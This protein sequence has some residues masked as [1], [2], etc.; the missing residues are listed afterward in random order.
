MRSEKVQEA[1]RAARASE[2]ADHSELR[3]SFRREQPLSPVGSPQPYTPPPPRSSSLFSPPEDD[4]PPLRAEFLVEFVRDFNR[5]SLAESKQTVASER[6]GPPPPRS[7][8]AIWSRTKTLAAS[9]SA[10]NG[11]ASKPHAVKLTSPA[12]IRFMIPDVLTAYISLVFTS[13]EDP[14]IVESVTAFGPREMCFRSTMAKMIQS[15]PRVPFQILISVLV[16]YGGLFVDRCTSCQRVLS[17]EGHFPPVG[18]IWVPKDHQLPP[19]NATSG[20]RVADSIDAAGQVAPP[21]PG[22]GDRTD[23]SS[24]RWEP[25][26]ATCLYN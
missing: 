14:L 9:A 5:G 1:L 7:R 20:K 6:D 17:A 13:L 4:P 3:L 23:H 18:R 12:V 21:A 8:L 15:H 2:E 25:R 24:G 11:I 10:A 26:H 16:S 22:A 19:A